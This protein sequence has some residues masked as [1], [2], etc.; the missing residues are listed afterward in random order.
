MVGRSEL[1]CKNPD[2]H[3][4]PDIPVYIHYEPTS[5]SVYFS[6]LFQYSFF[7]PLSIFTVISRSFGLKE[8]RV[9]LIRKLYL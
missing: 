9:A 8:K 1:F 5:S 2:G 7:E 3:C 4:F 6:Q